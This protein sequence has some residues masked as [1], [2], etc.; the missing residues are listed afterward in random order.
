M[1]GKAIGF[2]TSWGLLAV[3]GVVEELAA[4]S[5]G[6]RCYR[7]SCGDVLAVPGPSDF[8]G[9]YFRNPLLDVPDMILINS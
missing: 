2:G 8:L 1:D 3:V 9:A 6:P 5:F 4:E 7:S